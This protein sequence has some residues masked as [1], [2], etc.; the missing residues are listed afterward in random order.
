MRR[1]RVIPALL[2][3]SEGLYKTL[4]FREPKYIGDPINTVKI[5]NEKEAD[6]LL[7]L[8]I[9]ATS[10]GR[11][12][13]FEKIVE[14]ASE[15]FVPVGYGGGIRS[16]DDARRLL[17]GGVEKVIVNSRALERPALIQEL[18]SVFG[19]QSVV[20]SIDAKRTFWGR[21][22]VFG[23]GGTKAAGISVVAWA[24]EAERRGAGEIF[25]NSIDRDGTMSGYDLELIQS[26]CAV[27]SV[28]VVACGGAARLNDFV[29]AVN[30]GGAA[31]VA[32]GSL[33]VFQKTRSGILISFPSE[34]ELTRD[35]YAK[36][37]VNR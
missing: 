25:L 31:A 10:E 14:I 13:N 16:V 20:V 33:F 28:P 37:N 4:K 21:Y 26:V 3:K 2:L 27:V 5:F 36:L 7:I 35:F 32:A 9:S 12:P 19:S 8:D 24:R 30:T 15:A 18:A 1:I 23:C 34:D 11:R 17:G 29:E 6:E 22:K